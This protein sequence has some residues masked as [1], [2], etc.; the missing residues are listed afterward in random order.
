MTHYLTSDQ[1]ND[2]EDGQTKLMG[3][4]LDVISL[5]NQVVGDV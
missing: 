1:H 3:A 2:I 4:L 5:H